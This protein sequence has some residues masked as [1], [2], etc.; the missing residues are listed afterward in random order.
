MSTSVDR[1]NIKLSM[2][3]KRKRID[4]NLYTEWTQRPEALVMR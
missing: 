2:D 3:D 1:I 4:T